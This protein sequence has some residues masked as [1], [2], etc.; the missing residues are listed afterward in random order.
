M[1]IIVKQKCKYST[2]SKGNKE[3]GLFSEPETV[4]ATSVVS[5]KKQSENS[6][7]RYHTTFT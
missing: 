3:L 5:N 4:P 7:F 2:Q 6:A 1:H